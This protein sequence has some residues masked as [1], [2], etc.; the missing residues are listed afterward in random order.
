[1]N[2]E[3]NLSVLA[4]RLKDMVIET[5][6]TAQGFEMDNPDLLERNRYFRF[7]VKEGL[8]GIGLDE[9]KARAMIYAATSTYLETVNVMR[10][11]KQFVSVVSVDCKSRLI[12]RL[13][14]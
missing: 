12:P 10:R 9:F 3:G 14:R 5:E 7:T 1:M 8:R 4:S 11:A 6:R 13:I 2:L